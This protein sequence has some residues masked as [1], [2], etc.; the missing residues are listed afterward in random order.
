MGCMIRKRIFGSCLLT[1]LGVRAS[2]A[3]SS[4]FFGRSCTEI[5]GCF[6]KPRCSRFFVSAV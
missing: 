2:G 5:A 3:G 1:W 4:I 6:R